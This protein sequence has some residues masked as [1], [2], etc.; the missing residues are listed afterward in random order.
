M[1]T[2]RAAL[3][4]GVTWA[5]IYGGACLAGVGFTMSL[6]VT[7][8]AFDD[9]RVVAE[10]KLAILAASLMAAVWGAVILHR[11]LPKPA[12]LA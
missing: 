3:P 2:G 8:L 9:E 1:R 4:D 6:F 12:R 5:H 10:A 7:D 11:H